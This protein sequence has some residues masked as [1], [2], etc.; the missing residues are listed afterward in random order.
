MEDIDKVPSFWPDNDTIRTERKEIYSGDVERK[1]AQGR[2]VEQKG[3]T[4]LL[5]G[6]QL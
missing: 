6:F 3:G 5:C 4:A 2:M 1:L